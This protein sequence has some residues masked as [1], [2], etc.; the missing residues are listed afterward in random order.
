MNK[1]DF[2]LMEKKISDS[3]KYVDYIKK[4]FVEHD[5]HNGFNELDNLLAEFISLAEIDFSL[6]LSNMQLEERLKQITHLLTKRIDN[7][8]KMG[9]IIDNR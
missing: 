5:F 9:G 7:N 8:I 3:Y 1:K 4:L 6:H 2:E